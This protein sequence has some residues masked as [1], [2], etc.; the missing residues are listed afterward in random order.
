MKVMKNIRQIIFSFALVLALGVTLS[1]TTD[2]KAAT[3]VKQDVRP[4]MV[5]YVGNS[6]SL[7]G[8]EKY[9][10]KVYVGSEYNPT[11]GEW[12]SKYEEEER[13]RSYWDE[14]T[15]IKI[16]G[17]KVTKL[18]KKVRAILQSKNNRGYEFPVAYYN[19]A[20]YNTYADY[21]KATQKDTYKVKYDYEFVFR[22]AGTYTFTW[23][24]Y[25]LE[26]KDD[27]EVSQDPYIYLTNNYDVIKVVHTQK[28]KVLKDANYIKSI[29]LG[30][31]KYTNKATYKE[32]SSSTKRVVNK[33][34]TGTQG[35]L[36]VKTNKNYSV[37]SIIVQTYDAEGNTVYQAVNNKGIVSYG[38]YAWDGYPKATEKVKER[39]SKDLLKETTVYVGLTDKFTG[40]YTKYTIKTD[41]D[42]TKYVETEYKNSALDKEPTTDRGLYNWSYS[43]CSD[44]Y[45]FYIK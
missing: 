3:I 37:N 35:K 14:G 28:V 19:R 24:T 1:M 23:E 32:G 33:Y 45:T 34:L 41:T 25:R 8:E 4:A 9:M 39:I 2:A 26:E 40:A 5:S 44:A 13:T 16:N 17:K 20:Y 12:E 18:K 43:G 6:Y 31:A 36:T 27:V 10:A 29:T 30:K 11:T 7:Y 21:L 22:K 42:G 38:A 15:N